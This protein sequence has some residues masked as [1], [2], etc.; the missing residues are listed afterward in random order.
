MESLLLPL[1]ALG[2]AM[3]VFA[4]SL[5]AGTSGR[6]RSLRPRF[7]LAFHLGFFQGAMTLLG[8][9]LG[10]AVEPWIA[11]WD[12]WAAMGLLGI[13]GLRMIGEGLRPSRVEATLDVTRGGMLV[14][15]SM[16]TSIDAL[17]V[18]LGLAMLG[19]D[20]IQASVVIGLVSAILAILGARLGMWMGDRIGPRVE[21][22]GGL[23][24]LAIGIRIVWTH[25]A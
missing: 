21:I 9:L 23:I 12:H 13:V 18:G 7:R 25:M 17:A 14:A 8:W 10:Y 22:L 16:A 19:M 1:I 5:G 3:D 4:V 20:V 6:A 2:L 15:V 11:G 24:L